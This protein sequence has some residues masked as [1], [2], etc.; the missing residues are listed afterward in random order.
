M[1]EKTKAKNV[2]YT[3]MIGVGVS[4]ILVFVF[5]LFSF[6][7]HY[8]D[9]VFVR[10]ELHPERQMNVTYIV[11]EDK[12]LVYCTYNSE[13]LDCVPGV[14]YWFAEGIPSG[15]YGKRLLQVLDEVPDF[16]CTEG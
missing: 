2:G 10:A 4:M 5:I 11:L 16:N 3:I 7:I 14:R 15:N 6:P 9:G 12:T 8:E 1:D 13:V